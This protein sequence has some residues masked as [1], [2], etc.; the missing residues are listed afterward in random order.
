MFV[1]FQG[2]M[3]PNH[4]ITCACL[5]GH[6]KIVLMERNM[7]VLEVSFYYSLSISIDGTLHFVEIAEVLIYSLTF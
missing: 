2:E 1:F 6:L 4:I 3:E 5:C 7:G